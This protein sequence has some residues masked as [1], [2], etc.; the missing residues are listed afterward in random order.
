[1]SSSASW[2]PDSGATHHISNDLSNLNS[3]T[4]YHGGTQLQLGNG[5]GVKIANIGQL[6]VTSSAVASK[7]LLLDNILH[8]PDITRNLL[9]VSKFAKDN[10]AFF[11]FHPDFCLVKDLQTKAIILKGT[12]DQGLYHFLLPKPHI[13]SSSSSLSNSIKSTQ[14]PPTVCSVSLRNSPSVSSV[15]SLSCN[16]VSVG[17]IELWHRRLG[18]CAF[19]VVEKALRSCN[20][21]FNSMKSS[22]LCHPCCIAKSHRLPY[23]PSVSQHTIP[24]SLIHSDLWGP[25][26]MN[27]RN[28]FSYYVT[29]I[30]HFSTFTWLYLLKSK[31]EVLS[32]FKSFKAM[33]ENLLSCK[34]KTLQSDWGGEYQGLTSFFAR[35]WY[36]S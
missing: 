3:S 1:M 28:G 10:N 20:I 4:E 11:E 15:V 22:L 27:S 7:N 26:P 33:V 30:D 31:G 34:I 6:N 19:D 14:L 23:T 35:I 24:L 32:V 18:H 5:V 2:Y 9:S 25:A 17:N 36:C 29:F 8:V 16:S 12:L 21:P 13:K